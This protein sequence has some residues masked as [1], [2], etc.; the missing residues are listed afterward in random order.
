MMHRIWMD[1]WL[2]SK[3]MVSRY[4]QRLHHNFILLS[5]FPPPEDC[6]TL[7]YLM[8]KTMARMIEYVVCCSQLNT[9]PQQ[10]VSDVN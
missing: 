4:A 9:F 6:I 8:L 3:N 10:K 1:I 5:Y 7:D 2:Y